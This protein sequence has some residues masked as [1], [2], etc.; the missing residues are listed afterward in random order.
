LFVP[1]I[2]YDGMMGVECKDEGHADR[3]S[4]VSVTYSDAARDSLATLIHHIHVRHY[5]EASSLTISRT[6]LAFSNKYR[7]SEPISSF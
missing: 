6:F 1:S 2:Q 5:L 7:C 4:Q 3:G